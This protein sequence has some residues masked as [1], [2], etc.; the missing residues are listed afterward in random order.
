MYLYLY[1]IYIML[2]LKVIDEGKKR[3][4][5]YHKKIF[6]QLNTKTKNNLKLLSGKYNDFT[7]I[8]LHT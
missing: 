7:N 1:V 4:I 8:N 5:A 3:K 6:P 2:S